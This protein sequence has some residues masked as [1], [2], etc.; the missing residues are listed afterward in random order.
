MQV[1]ASVQSVHM[2]TCS[3]W[4]NVVSDDAYMLVPV[5]TSVLV[6]E[7]D[8][9]AEFMNHDA[10]LITVLPYGDGLW[11]TTPPTHVGATP[12]GSDSTRCLL[13]GFICQ[14]FPLCLTATEQLIQLP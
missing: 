6:P 13:S 2:Q 10:K 9:V 8:D 3:T 11:A 7:A 5:R 4:L 14:L 12:A 1:E